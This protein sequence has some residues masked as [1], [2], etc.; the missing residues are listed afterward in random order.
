LDNLQ[1]LSIN[2]KSGRL[3]VDGKTLKEQLSNKKL[4]SEKKTDL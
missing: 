2:E 1:S 4:Y 3:T